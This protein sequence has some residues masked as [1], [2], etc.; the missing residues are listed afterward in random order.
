MISPCPLLA[1]SGH[2]LVHRKCP[3]LEV[4]RTWLRPRGMSANCPTSTFLACPLDVFGSH[5]W[6]SLRELPLYPRNGG[7]RVRSDGE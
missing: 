6:N 7:G 2:E 4:K 3:L 1:L 5:N